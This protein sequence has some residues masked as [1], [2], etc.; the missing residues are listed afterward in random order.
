VKKN[1]RLIQYFD[2]DIHGKTHARDIKH[3]MSSPR[4]ICE[5]FGEFSV[6]R[7]LNKA[8]KKV[9]SRSKQEYRL[10]DMEEHCDY[11]VLLINVVDTDA[12]N[13]VTQKIDGTDQD[14]EVIELGKDRG[15][16]SSSHVIVY[17]DKNLAGKHLCLFEKSSSLPFAKAMTFL[18][19]LCK[20]AAKHFKDQYSVPH[21]SG[22][23]GKKIKLYCQIAFLG[24]PSDEFKEELEQGVL[25]D[26]KITT[27]MDI[28]KGYDSNVHTELVSTDI[29]MNVGRVAVAMSGGN[30]SHLKKAIRY[31]DSLDSPLVRVAFTDQSGAGH[32]ATIS[33]DTGNLYNADKYIKK[34]KIQGFS[35][36][37]R[38]AF[39]VIQDS[40]RDKM[41]E[42]LEND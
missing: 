31:A 20:E 36:A 41:L 3:K 4:K 30:W 27:D 29:K 14:R 18:N 34:R 10:E 6:L 7:E 15:L 22:E 40:I 5:L 9:S 23:K 38:T 2:L 24:H 42:T 26:I 39:P 25:K 35:I 37:L 1:E 28:V 32:T 11:W 8:R 12:A 16:E 19:F 21:P 17:K 33:T 13:P